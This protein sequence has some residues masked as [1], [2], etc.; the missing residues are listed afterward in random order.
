MGKLLLASSLALLVAG[1]AMAAGTNLAW[2]DCLGDG[3]GAHD[4][5]IDCTNAGSGTMYLTFVPATNFASIG[6]IDAFID[7]VPA[8]ARLT[9]SSWWSPTSISARCA[10]ESTEPQSGACP[11]WWTGAT[12]GP[13]L[14]ITGSIVNGGAAYRVNLTSVIAA[15]EER[16]AAPGTEY[17]AG[18]VDLRFSAGTL[19]NAECH[20]GAV[21]NVYD[22][23]VEQPA[24]P[25]SHFGQAAEVSNTITFQNPSTILGVTPTRK[26]SWGALKA[27]YR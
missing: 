7:V 12:D 3:G 26:T 10:F 5:T 21:I 25:Y 16:Q 6:C 11:A 20:A 2:N 8:A 14:Y 4:R 15:G 9:G 17:F 27:T 24:L 19:G 13:L 23:V 22:L 1:S 18:A